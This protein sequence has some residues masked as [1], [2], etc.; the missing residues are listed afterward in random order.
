MQLFPG[1]YS[2]AGIGKWFL[3]FFFLCIFHVSKAQNLKD[4]LAFPMIGFQY[5][6]DVPVGHLS[7]EFGVSSKAGA[8]IW[9]KTSK[10]WLF[11]VEYNYIFGGQVKLDPLDSIKTKEGYIL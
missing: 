6:F 5:G 9:Y 8:S 2:V 1:K 10:N 3:A 7:T 4:T 11:G